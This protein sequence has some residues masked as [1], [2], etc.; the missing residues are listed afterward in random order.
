MATGASFVRLKAQVLSKVGCAARC[1]P[2]AI[3]AAACSASPSLPPLDRIET[4]TLPRSHDVQGGRG[5]IT[6]S[7]C[8][9]WSISAGVLPFA[10]P[11]AC[12]PG[13]PL[14][15]G[16]LPWAARLP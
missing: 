12:L 5:V 1:P 9:S 6:L 2:P 14:G 10:S 13:G 4:D 8:P 16:A 3:L 15:A 7:P 11:A